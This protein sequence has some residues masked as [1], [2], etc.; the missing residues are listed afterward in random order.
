MWMHG[1]VP[2]CVPCVLATMSSLLAPDACACVCMCMCVWLRDCL[3]VPG[4]P[5]VKFT[6]V[7]RGFNRKQAARGFFELLVLKSWDC[8]DVKQ[9]VPYT[10]ITISKSVRSY[11]KPS[12]S[13][14]PTHSLGNRGPST[15]STCRLPRWLSRSDLVWMSYLPGSICPG[16]S[17][18]SHC[19][20]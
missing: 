6:E 12:T 1:S 7:S 19:V 3:Y 8:I 4:Q 11:G 14:T 16:C 18:R 9:A 15:D 20:E 17:R 5:A 10:D 13:R 2:G